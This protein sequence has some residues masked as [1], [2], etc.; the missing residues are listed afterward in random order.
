MLK[1][2]ARSRGCKGQGKGL[3]MNETPVGDRPVV[4]VECSTVVLKVS[5]VQ[6]NS[7]TWSTVCSCK[8]FSFR[9]KILDH[10]RRQRRI[11]VFGGD[12]LMARNRNR[13]FSQTI[14][15]ICCIVAS[16]ARGIVVLAV[17][18]GASV[19][20][21]GTSKTFLLASQI[22][23]PVYYSSTP[24]FRRL[25]FL[26]HASLSSVQSTQQTAMLQHSSEVSSWPSAFHLF[27]IP[28]AIVIYSIT[29]FDDS[30]MSP[31]FDFIT[32]WDGDQ[33]TA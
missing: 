4:A 24:V 3:E 23:N 7:W 2:L 15:V 28:V 17:V 20:P 30:D 29:V 8:P 14:D 21:R 31:C 9:G 13:V 26:G 5:H 18:M 1:W 25:S 6:Q 16:W 32:S 19:K 33:T 11:D 22:S 27:R 10:S 12:N